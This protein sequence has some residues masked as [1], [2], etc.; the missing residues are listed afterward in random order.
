MDSPKKLAITAIGDSEGESFIASSLERQGWK[1]IYRALVQRELEIFL[2]SLDG[3]EV[4]L[5]TAPDFSKVPVTTYSRN[6][7]THVVNLRTI[8]TN[9][10]DFSEDIRSTGEA[11]SR[12]WATI[13][14]VPIIALTS[15]GRTVGTST[16]ALNIA[17]ELAERGSEVLLIDAHF[18]SPFLSPYLQTFGVKREL[19]RT[20]QGFSIFEVDSQNSFR[21]IEQEVA[22]F[23]ALVIDIGEIWQP[24][25][26]ISGSRFEDYAFSWSSHYASSMISISA[27]CG[28]SAGVIGEKLLE[29]ERLSLKPKLSHLINLTQELSPKE[30]V[31]KIDGLER[32][33]HLRPSF[34][35]RDD[36]A[37]SRARAINSTLIASAPKSALR[38]A[39]ARF[40]QESNWWMG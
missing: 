27:D 16:I 15:F 10:H 9:D 40:C 31:M 30:R 3:Q 24:A 8:P 37:L 28:I 36:R 14:S 18:R 22:Q 29:L 11:I 1:V 13:P 39:I 23:D 2:D 7:N 21:T 4:T 38:A 34:L 5:F 33:L 19:I 12:D 25:N 6:Q 32:E 26:S 35:P 20:A 17:A